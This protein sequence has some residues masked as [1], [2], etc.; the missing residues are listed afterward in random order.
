[1]HPQFLIIAAGLLNERRAILRIFFQGCI[2]ERFSYF[3]VWLAELVD[4]SI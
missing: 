3:D 1:V 2:K 4:D